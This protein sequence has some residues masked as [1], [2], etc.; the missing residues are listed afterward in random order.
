MLNF[1]SKDNFRAQVERSTNGL[2]TVIYD[3]YGYPNIMYVIEPPIG[4]HPAFE[5]ST[6]YI[7]R[8]FISKY[9]TCNSNDL[10][11][12][13]ISQAGL[14]PIINNFDIFQDDTNNLDNFRSD[15]ATD[16]GENWHYTNVLEWN[17]Y[18]IQTLNSNPY[19][20][21]MYDLTYLKN[22]N[23][24]INSI[25]QKY[26]SIAVNTQYD[27]IDIDDVV[28][29]ME[30]G[31]EQPV[32][33]TLKHILQDKTSFGE[34]D[35]N[36]VGTTYLFEYDNLN[37][38]LLKKYID[39]GE[40]FYSLYFSGSSSADFNIQN[41]VDF[42]GKSIEK[43]TGIISYSTGSKNSFVDG[44]FGLNDVYYEQ[45]MPGVLEWLDGAYLFS[46]DALQNDNLAAIGVLENNYKTL[47]DLS[48]THAA[49]CIIGR[50]SG[51]TGW[52]IATSDTGLGSILNPSPWYSVTANFAS[53]AEDVQHIVE[54]TFNLNISQTNLLDIIQRITVADE[55]KLKDEFV[56]LNDFDTN[57]KLPK[58]FY[59]YPMRQNR[60][61]YIWIKGADDGGDFGD[62][63]GYNDPNDTY[64]GFTTRLTYVE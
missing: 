23:Q 61:N 34:D 4:G 38:N 11:N 45:F 18:L 24:E 40:G 28:Y 29:L 12:T 14:T 31:E 48:I 8:V 46:A 53:V 39:V 2:N 42:Q 22:T 47:T 10:N 36:K 35:E 20:P 59:H 32:Q 3:Q 62:G 55:Y 64:M 37:I 6:G 43:A 41:T 44:A 9:A 50:Q 26:F 63:D 13:P 25:G 49:G 1:F 56:I 5:T 19:R 21:E 51:E 54:A 16:K 7:N 15:L 17:A 57:E 33:L 60:F 27:G 30:D 52:R 58:D